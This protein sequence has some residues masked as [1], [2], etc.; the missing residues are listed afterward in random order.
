[1]RSK[2]TPIPKI[3]F[4]IIVLNG[5]PFTRYNLRAL[6]PFAHE[7]IVV[8][9][10]N[11]AS[12]G[13]ADPDGHSLDGTLEVLQSFK[14]NEDPEGK[15][16]IVTR[17]G[18]W[19]EKDEQSQAYAE[20]A[21][22]DYLWQIDIDEFYLPDD[23]RRIARILH[24]D[25]EVT[26]INVDC[27]NFFG[28]VDYLVDGMFLKRFFR[29]MRGVP[30]IFRWGDGSRYI[31]HRPPTV[32][33]SNGNDMRALKLIEGRVLSRLGIYCYHYGLSFPEQVRHK[34]AYYQRKGWKNHDRVEQW[35][36]STFRRIERP[37]HIHHVQNEVSWLDRFEGTQPPQIQQMIT[38]MSS[39]RLAIPQRQIDDI[40]QILRSRR[41]RAGRMLFNQLSPFV[42]PLGRWTFGIDRLVMNILARVLSPRTQVR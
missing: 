8:E 14:A 24:Y 39:G 27:L 17:D 37:F 21:T 23:M 18:F 28:G 31:T 29:N 13:A 41:Y 6:Y 15:I 42:L 16:Q 7:I 33:D 12:A 32:I 40:E 3:T 25:S 26:Q 9:G 36:E 22:G 38:D 30:R 19:S 35:A 1:M 20:L 34:M 5:E 2:T 4:G 10:A 11:P